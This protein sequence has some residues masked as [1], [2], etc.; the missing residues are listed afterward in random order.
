MDNVL[1]NY[2]FISE[3]DFSQ[4][5]E[6]ELFTIGDVLRYFITA[7]EKSG[8]FCGQGASD[9]YEEAVQ[10]LSFV[11]GLT[12]NDVL[13]FQ[14]SRL[15]QRERLQAAQILTM[16]IADRVPAAYITNVAYFDRKTFY[17]DER[18]LIPRSPIAELIKNGFKGYLPENAAI[19]LD[20]CTGSGCIAI[21]M[22]IDLHIAMDAVDISEE[23]LEVC[24]YNIALHN[25]QE[26]VCP[27][28][29]DL[30][31][32][33]NPEIK[34]D[35]IVSNPPYVGQEEFMDLPDE[36]SQEPENALISGEDGLDA[37]RIIL[38]ES[39]RYLKEGCW[40]ICEVGNTRDQLIEEYP[41]APFHWIE[42]KNGGTGVFAV[43]REELL[44]YK[45]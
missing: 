5:L 6:N 9:A 20:M 13:D 23:A 18:V 2:N 22:A 12:Y 42:L 45:F 1:S 4:E 3:E 14:Q 34:Y 29:S 25:Q 8:A 28:K 33:L 43:S 44:T 36:F 21:S 39:S 31:S 15:T 41:D 16:R 7:I 27:I 24:E 11:T 35:I 40:L 17:V 19:G 30:F 26:Q 38:R 32:E 10:L 37:T